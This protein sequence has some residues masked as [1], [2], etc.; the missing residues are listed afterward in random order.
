MRLSQRDADQHVRHVCE[1]WWP[2]QATKRGYQRPKGASSPVVLACCFPW[3]YVYANSEAVC[4]VLRQARVFLSASTQSCHLKTSSCIHIH[5]SRIR[6]LTRLHRRLLVHV[7]MIM[8]QEFTNSLRAGAVRP[9]TGG[10]RDRPT[11]GGPPRTGRSA[12]GSTSEYLKQQIAERE[13]AAIVFVFWIAVFFVCIGVVCRL[14]ESLCTASLLDTATLV[15]RP[16]G[17][18]VEHCAA[19]LLVDTVSCQCL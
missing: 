12:E 7:Q 2:Q 5:S 4:V 14:W 13:C 19:A 16:C 1:W 10:T 11:V 18:D 15:A 8:V 6:S 17:L 9:L 3:T